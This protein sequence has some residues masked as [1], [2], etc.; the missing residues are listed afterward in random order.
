[1]VLSERSTKPLLMISVNIR[2]QFLQVQT[3]LMSFFAMIQKDHQPTNYLPIKNCRLLQKTYKH[4][5]SKTF[6]QHVFHVEQLFS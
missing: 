2:V 6:W 4:D 1:L 5:C 3:L